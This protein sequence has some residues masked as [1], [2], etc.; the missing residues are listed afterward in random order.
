[1]AGRIQYGVELVDRVAGDGLEPE[2][3]SG[4]LTINITAK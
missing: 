3:R 1:V 2:I 4:T